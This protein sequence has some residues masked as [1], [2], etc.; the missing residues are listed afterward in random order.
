MSLTLV[1]LLQQKQPV[2][3]DGIFVSMIGKTVVKKQSHWKPNTMRNSY[4]VHSNLNTSGDQ[5]NPLTNSVALSFKSPQSSAPYSLPGEGMSRASQD[6]MFDKLHHGKS[7]LRADP[8][9]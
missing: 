2:I 3:E 7:F 9:P 8:Q 5:F 6:E 1:R 4:Q